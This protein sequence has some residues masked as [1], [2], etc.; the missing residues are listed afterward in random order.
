MLNIECHM[1]YVDVVC[2]MSKFKGQKDPGLEKFIT[3]DHNYLHVKFKAYSHHISNVYQMCIFQIYYKC[4]TNL[5]QKSNLS[6]FV[7]SRDKLIHS[8]AAFSRINISIAISHS[9]FGASGGANLSSHGATQ[10]VSVIQLFGH[11]IF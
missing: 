4:F 9:F 2:Q 8:L 6:F 1:S 11:C 5:F 7:N 3:K 10:K